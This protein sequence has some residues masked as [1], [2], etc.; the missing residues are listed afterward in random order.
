MV[1]N[2]RQYQR[3]T[4]HTVEMANAPTAK[5]QTIFLMKL[6]SVYSFSIPAPSYPIEK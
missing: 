3:C 1:T 5:Y 6:K 2:L 4:K